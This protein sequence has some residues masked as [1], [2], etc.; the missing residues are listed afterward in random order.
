MKIPPLLL[1]A[2]AAAAYWWW[3]SGRVKTSAGVGEKMPNA[4]AGTTTKVD[5]LQTALQSK[6]PPASLP[7]PWE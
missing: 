4:D 7:A 2:G 3:S 6:L 5:H 1:I